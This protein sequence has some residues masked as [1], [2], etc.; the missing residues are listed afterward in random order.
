MAINTTLDNVQLL[1]VGIFN[2]REPQMGLR[3]ALKSVS[4]RYLE[5]DWQ[6]A[7]SSLNKWI[8]LQLSTGLFDV[9]FMQIQTPNVISLDLLKKWHKKVRFF[10]FNGDLRRPMPVWYIEVAPYVTSLI[11]NEDDV[12]Q[13]CDAGYEAH[14]F[15]I[16]YDKNI[17]TPD[18]IVKHDADVVFMGNNFVHQFGLTQL[19]KD[20]VHRLQRE[21]PA[22][23]KVYGANWGSD[24]RHTNFQQIIE[25]SIYRGSK[26]AINLS[27]ENAGRYTSDRI[28]RLMACGALC[29]SH[30]YPGI[31]K[32]FIIGE[33]LFVW[34]DLD[35]LVNMI[36][37][38]QLNKNSEQVAKV[39]KQGCEYVRNFFGWDYRIQNQFLS[40]L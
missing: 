2:N 11:T 15:Q 5:I 3:N 33:H 40:L 19:R 17:Y 18:G 21:F 14:F 13:I 36:T 20:M 34:D 4:A 24:V 38:L 6:S 28:F 26:M 10:N 31:E 29:L 27:H 32:D 7:G 8:D 1:H 39:A 37:Y 22:S 9:V 23:F 12:K 25:A 35:T 16:G 30:R